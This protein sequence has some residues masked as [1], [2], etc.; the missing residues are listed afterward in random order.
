MAL[1]AAEF[2][3]QFRFTT[4]ARV[5]CQQRGIPVDAVKTVLRYGR[6]YHAGEG[7]YAYFLGKRAVRR[8]LARY[9]VRVERWINAAVIVGPDNAVVTV[10]RAPRP[11]R[12]WRGRH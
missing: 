11:K 8:A 10:Q 1:A 5:R 6:K 3:R 2:R 7:Q 12:S 4:H 9:G